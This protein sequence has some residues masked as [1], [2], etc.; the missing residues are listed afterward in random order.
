MTALIEG[1]VNR[2]HSIWGQA[3]VTLPAA[4]GRRGGDWAAMNPVVIAAYAL[5]ALLG[6][7]ASRGGRFADVWGHFV[8]AQILA[9]AVTLSVVAV[10]RINGVDGL[11]W[12][13]LLALGFGLVSLAALVTQS[14][15]R[16]GAIA[17][18]E[19]W[20]AG[21]NSA[22]WV[23]PLATAIAGPSAG[24][25]AVLVDRLVQPLYGWWIH[26]LRRAAPTP[27]RARTGWIDQAPVLALFVGLALRLYGP[28]PEW[29]GTITVWVAPLLAVSGAAVFVGSVLHPSQRIDPRPGIPRFLLLSAVRIVGFGVLAVA[30]P[31]VPLKVVAVLCALSCPA[32]GATQ[33]STVYGYA[34][35][36]VAAG[37]RYGWFAGALGIVGALLIGHA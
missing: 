35:P 34:D 6:Y 8:R 25:A 11:L 30:A 9:V 32:F 2:G 1:D 10:W 23:I 3:P 4:A 22:F 31:T 36:V 19:G 26:L 18:L 29:T 12:P 14:R 13:V 28:A 17:S 5:G 27:Q 15:P 20:T 16:S 37:I 7:L 21:P 33:F 24:L